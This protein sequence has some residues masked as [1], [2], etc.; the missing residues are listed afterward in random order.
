M[1]QYEERLAVREKIVV[2]EQHWATRQHSSC[3]AAWVV[4]TEHRRRRKHMN[5]I[6]TSPGCI[7]MYNVVLC[8]V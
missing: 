6:E 4:Y 5:G 7:Y 1:R 2:A 8:V 3:W